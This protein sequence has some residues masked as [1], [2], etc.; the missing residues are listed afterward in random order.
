MTLTV[1]LLYPTGVGMM[2]AMRSYSYVYGYSLPR[3][4]VVEDVSTVSSAHAVPILMYHG[5][6]DNGLLG[7]NTMRAN[8]IAQMEMLKRKGYTTISIREYDLFRE[9]KFTLPAKPV[10]ITF[11]D[12]RKDSFYTVDRILEKLG[13][14]AAIFVATVKAN[15]QDPFYL[16][17][18]TL[19]HMW[20]TGRW[21]IEAH[22]RNSHDD[23]LINE[24]GVYGTYLTSRMYASLAGLES[25]EE[26]KKRIE[27]DYINGIMDI[28][29]HL[30][31]DAR[32]FAVPLNDYGDHETSNY[33]GS[34]AFNEELTRRFFRLAFVQAQQ[35]DGVAL[36]SFYNDSNSDPYTLKRLEVGNMNS[37]NLAKELE[38]FEP[39]VPK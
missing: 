3:D 33:G 36:E 24:E 29:T 12:G 1:I 28:K 23:I 18:D 9:G 26:Y 6:V 16:G 5:V 17:W 35:L 15:E 21:E 4:L 31:I 32:Y 8:F 7:A 10:I 37:E 34:Y 19:A 13:F 27:K 30:G 39:R 14:K 2:N 25:V 38:R 20:S 22:G 11:D